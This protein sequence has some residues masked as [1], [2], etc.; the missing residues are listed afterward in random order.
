MT[1]QSMTAQQGQKARLP[2]ILFMILALAKVSGLMFFGPLQQPDSIAYLSYAH[3]ILTDTGW[4]S[5]GAMNDFAVPQ[6]VFRTFGYPALI[7]AAGFITGKSG[8]ALYVVVAIQLVVSLFATVMVYRLGLVL[9]RNM[10]LALLAAA[11]HALSVTI[12]Y[13]QHILTD[14]LFNALCVIGFTT[15]IIGFLQKRPPGPWLLLGLG[16]MLGYACLV[17]GIGLYVLVFF[18]PAYIAWFVVAHEQTAKTM[19]GVLL[20]VLPLAIVIGGVMSWNTWRTGYTF[21]TT[22][23]QYVLIQPLVKI[24]GRG[25][26]VFDGDTPLDKLAQKYLKTYEYKEAVQITE[27]LF[28]EYGINAYDSAKMHSQKYFSTLASQP[29]AVLYHGVR[30]YEEGLVHQFFNVLDNAKIYFKFATGVKPWPGTKELWQRARDERNPLDIVLILG[31]AIL[32][33][34]AWSSFL[35]LLIGVPVV[36]IRALRNGISLPADV[37]AIFYCWGLYFAYSFGLSMIHMVDR[38]LPA[39]LAAGLVGS[40]FVWQQ[41]WRIFR[42]NSH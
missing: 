3:T 35:V 22:G 28:T 19:R 34:V 2:G 14:S 12:T 13:D 27:A 7:A 32:R 18:A 16:I 39:V 41:I 5:D 21:F 15:P 33:L 23:A 42:K 37:L 29:G 1:A 20:L 40:L 38:F 11:A 30:N 24:E 9:L 25:T 4:L 26:K 10:N 6:T 31:L 36:V 17:R 8:V